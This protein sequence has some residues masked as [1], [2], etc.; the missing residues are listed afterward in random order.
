MEINFQKSKIMY[1]SKSK[2][3]LMEEKLSFNGHQ[4][5]CADE[6]KYLGIIL[7]NNLNFSKHISKVYQNVYLTCNTIRNIKRY[8]PFETFKIISNAFILSQYSYCID[9]WSFNPKKTYKIQHC[10]NKLLIEYSYPSTFNKLNNK[11]KRFNHTKRSI[12]NFTSNRNSNDILT[13]FNI[14]TVNELCELS[15]IKNF[16]KYGLRNEESLRNRYVYTKN[17][18]SSRNLPLLL[19]PKIESE[20][21]RKSTVYRTIKLWNSLPKEWIFD[22]AMPYKFEEECKNY[23]LYKRKQQKFYFI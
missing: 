1:F 2:E 7:Y 4:L 9:I 23:I 12:Y 3:K 14:L 19:I 20:T 5:D 16:I 11:F 17:T 8:L 21:I 22:I 6:F 13:K 18:R 15:L 10:I